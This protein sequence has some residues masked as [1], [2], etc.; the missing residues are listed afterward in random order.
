MLAWWLDNLYVDG[1]AS[2]NDFIMQFQADLL[3]IPVIQSE[4]V[5]T[6][7]LGVW[8]TWRALRRSFGE[9]RE[10]IE[11]NRTIAE[12]FDPRMGEE[13]RAQVLAGWHDAVACTRSH[14]GGWTPSVSAPYE[15]GSAA[16]LRV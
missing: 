4:S 9:D 5:E 12:R 13:R 2:R 15:D 8:P 10:E 14:A 3:S 1:A 16:T 11:Q 6:T 7:A